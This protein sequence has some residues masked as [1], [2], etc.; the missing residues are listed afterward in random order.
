MGQRRTA[1]ELLQ[2]GAL[3]GGD[4]QDRGFGTPHS[5]TSGRVE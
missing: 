2:N 1:G 5:N 3:A 4:G